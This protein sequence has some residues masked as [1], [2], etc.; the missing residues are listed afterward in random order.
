[1]ITQPGQARKAEAEMIFE[2]SRWYT[3]RGQLAICLVDK[4]STKLYCMLRLF[5]SQFLFKLEER[6]VMAGEI[7]VYS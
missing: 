1:M 4:Q 6:R 5:L 3:Y 2:L 7:P